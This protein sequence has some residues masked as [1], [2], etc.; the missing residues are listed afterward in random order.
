MTHQPASPSVI[1]LQDAGSTIMPWAG[2]S[3]FQRRPTMQKA[4]HHTRCQHD[5]C[6]RVS[7]WASE[8]GLMSPTIHY[9]R[10]FRKR[11]FPV[12]HLHWYWQPNKNNQAT[13]HTNNITRNQKSHLKG[14]AIPAG[15]KEKCYATWFQL[16]PISVVTIQR[17]WHKLVPLIV[18]VL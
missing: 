17:I 10:S 15:C 16:I 3:K 12:N 8:C 5:L 18:Y 11:V 13:E 7:E 14:N 6:T 9:Y 1:L 2:H 4:F